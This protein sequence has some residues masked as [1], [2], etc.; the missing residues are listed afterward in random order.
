MDLIVVASHPIQYQA[1]IWRELAKLGSLRFEVWYGSDYGVRPQKSG[2]GLRDF[3]WDVD[4]TSG[5]PHRF[6]PN[7]SPRKAPDTYAGKLH[8]GLPFELI[9]RRPRAV[10]V[11]GYR[12]L[13]EQSAIFGAKLAR[14][15]LV[16]RAD[17][18]ARTSRGSWRKLARKAYLSVLY[19]NLDAILAIGPDNRRHYEEHGVPGHKLIDAPYSIDQEFF[20]TLAE[21]ARPHRAV[22]REQLGLPRDR[23][24][25]LFGGVLRDIKGVDIL[26]RALGDLP[27][28][29]LAIA[30][31]GPEQDALRE[32]AAT[33][34]LGRVH[35]LGFLNQRELAAAY[36]WADLL[37]LP[38]RQEAWGLVVNEA[39]AAGTPVVVSEACGV[40]AQVKATGAGLTV[41]PDSA[42]LLATALKRALE[43]AAAGRFSGG[44]QAFNERHHPRKTAEAIVAAVRGTPPL[45]R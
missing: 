36:A 29:H 8:P 43:E 26:V 33:V 5:Y 18:N 4:L 16:F 23:P 19:P 9:L 6:L 31:S 15:R 28:A 35:F 44:V 21:R 41:R 40:A 14:S 24:V 25:I 17:T 30:G 1:C 2:W 34:A 12:N 20:R 32:L 38:S 42:E 3:A 7:L 10:L 13:H 39:I 27:E 45:A 37:C 11:Q 22:L